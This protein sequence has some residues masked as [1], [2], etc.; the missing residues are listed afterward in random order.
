MRTLLALA[1][2]CAVALTSFLVIDALT[3]LAYSAKPTLV[4]F[5]STRKLPSDI[6]VLYLAGVAADG[7]EQSEAI[8]GVIL[9]E[10]DLIAV[11]YSRYRH[12]AATIVR[13]AH[14]WLL[15]HGYRRVTLVG[16]SMGGDIVSDF[17]AYNRAKDS[18]LHLRAIL[19]DVPAGRNTLFQ[20]LLPVATYAWYPG[21]FQNWLTVPFWKVMYSPPAPS[22][23]E[24]G[25]N[26]AQLAAGINTNLHWPLSCYAGEIRYVGKFTPPHAGAYADIPAVIIRSVPGYTKGDDVVTS[27]ADTIWEGVFRT[28]NLVK[29]DSTHINFAGNPSANRAGYQRAIAILGPWPAN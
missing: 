19:D 16:G 22:Q 4:K 1:A 27:E 23:L 17:I 3:G 24:A 2:I 26:P 28:A 14:K 15:D 6:G 18:P 8:R 5:A 13:T 20:S 7:V 21:W 12:D 11:K 29:V 9:E 25:Y 10:G